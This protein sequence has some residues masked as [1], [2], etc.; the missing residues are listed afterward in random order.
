MDLHTTFN[1][2][3]DWIINEI[4]LKCEAERVRFS[5]ELPKAIYM[6]V[7]MPLEANLNTGYYLAAGE[8]HPKP[9]L[10]G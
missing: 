6:I 1:G 7:T 8:G 2:S 3:L 9:P 4:E 10:F 5:T